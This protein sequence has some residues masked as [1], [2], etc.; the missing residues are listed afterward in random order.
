MNLENC[1]YPMNVR[2]LQALCGLSLH[3]QH[4]IHSMSPGGD[5]HCKRTVYAMGY[6]TELF[7]PAPVMVGPVGHDSPTAA[8][9]PRSP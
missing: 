7:I 2:V 1:Y 4:R 6:L 5:G 8:C 3:M 9:V